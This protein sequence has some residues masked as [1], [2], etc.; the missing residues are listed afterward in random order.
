MNK[1]LIQNWINKVVDESGLDEPLYSAVKYVFACG[2]KRLRPLMFLSA[3]LLSGK[4]ITDSVRDFAVAIEC[5]HQYTLVHDDLPCMDNDDFRRGK[6]TCHK[7]F[8]EANAL[9]VGDTLL[10]LCFTLMLRSAQKDANAAKAAY[11]F[12]LLSGGA[13]VI[14]GQAAELNSINFAEQVEDIYYKKTCYLIWG[15]VL[16]GAIMG[17][18]DEK[19]TLAL[20]EYCFNFGFAFQVYDDLM[21]IT[22]KGNAPTNSYVGL[23][24]VEKSVQTVKCCT[25]KAIDALKEANI[26]SDYFVDLALRA[27]GRKE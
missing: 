7:M 2:G 13:G 8:G 14:G 22:E 4:L 19:T 3:Y 23:F 9:L 1:E 11:E 17:G 10:N 15:A 6:P 20:K 5:L 25:Q 12:S 21:D 26:N 27:A 16:C 18:L 24:G